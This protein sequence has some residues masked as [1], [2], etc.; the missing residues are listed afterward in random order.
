MGE[1]IVSGLLR[2]ELVAPESMTCSD[3]LPARLETLK[4][5]YGIQTTTDN[6]EAVEKADIVVLSTKPQ[7]I[8][9]VMRGLHGFLKPEQLVFSILAGVTTK[10]LRRGFDHEAV[11]RVMPNTPAQLGEGMSVWT[12]TPAVTG[13]QREKAQKI[14]EALGEEVFVSKEDELDMAT[15]LS[16]TGPAY[17]FLFMEALVDAGVHLGFSRRV[18]E[19]LVLQTCKG[20]VDYALKSPR[21]LAELRNQVTSPGGTTADALYHIEKGG[22]RTVVS[23]AVFAAY[24]KSQYLSRLV[25]ED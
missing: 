9:D 23:K 5:R 14:L 4:E 18:A 20:S 16:G 1:A 12:C 25:E 7:V 6:R 15:A 13:V 17:V 22:M 2:D 24:K 11:V 10:T 19:K 8:E 3:P 21:H